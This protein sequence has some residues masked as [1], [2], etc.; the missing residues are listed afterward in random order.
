MAAGPASLWLLDGDTEQLVAEL[1]APEAGASVL[2]DGSI[3]EIFDGG[4]APLTA[5]AYPTARSAWVVRGGATPV[6]AWRLDVA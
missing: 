1:E 3:V 2:V 5:R 6:G 4:A